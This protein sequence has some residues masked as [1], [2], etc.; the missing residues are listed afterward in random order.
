MPQVFNIV[1]MGPPGAGKSTQAEA[2]ASRYGLSRLSTGDM[3][4]DEIK[5]DS[6]LSQKL[7]EI[8]ARGDM[9]PESLIYKLVAQ[10]LSSADNKNGFILDGFPRNETQARWLDKFMKKNGMKINTVVEIAV[11][12]Q[13]IIT[14]ICGR[15][16][17][18]EC[19]ETYHITHKQPEK[20]NECDSCGAED[21]FQRRADDNQGVVRNRIEIYKKTTADVLAYYKNT[22]RLKTVDGSQPVPAVGKEIIKLLDGL[23]P[24]GK[25]AY[26]DKYKRKGL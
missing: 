8:V 12:D 6:P 10:N 25:P 2:I 14:R 1:I 18:S 24:S 4:R 15:F 13:E 11:K 16:S 22:A 9:A 5:K 23:R 20:E 7:R 3:V 26:A 19:D 17:C 21:S